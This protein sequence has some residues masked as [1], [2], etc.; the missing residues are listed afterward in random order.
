MSTLWAHRVT[1]T[2]YLFSYRSATKLVDKFNSVMNK[3]MNPMNKKKHVYQDFSESVVNFDYLDAAHKIAHNPLGI[4]KALELRKV[5]A[6]TW[7]KKPDKQFI[8]RFTRVRTFF[9]HFPKHQ[10]LRFSNIKIHFAL[11]DSC[12]PTLFPSTY[13]KSKRTFL[14]I[15]RYTH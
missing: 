4:I 11:F 8:F 7:F 9:P 13:V 1:S 10:T 5:K 6:H 14:Y 3:K 15:A 2:N 12:F